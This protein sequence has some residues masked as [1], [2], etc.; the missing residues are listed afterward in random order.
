MCI[1]NKFIAVALCAVVMFVG[2]FALGSTAA[3]AQSSTG[4]ATTTASVLSIEQLRQ[5]VNSL[6]QQI[7]QLIKL[8]AVLKPQETCGNGICRFGETAT[9]CPTDCG[10]VVTC[11]GEGQTAGGGLVPYGTVGLKCCAGLT[12]MDQNIGVK[13]DGACGNVGAD[14]SPICTKCGNGVCGQGENKCNCPADCK[15]TGCATE[16]QGIYSFDTAT[17]CCSGLKK[18]SSSA[19]NDYPT[20]SNIPVADVYSH[21]CIKCGDGICGT[22]ENKCNCSADCQ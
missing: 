11:A 4:S 14:M 12:P 22:R 13:A 10:G 15:S 8:I 17:Q 3:Q 7:Q 18:V 5:I 2:V 6:I 20:C 21:Y 1:K 16:G 9:T 19:A